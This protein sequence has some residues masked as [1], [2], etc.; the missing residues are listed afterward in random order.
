[1]RVGKID[2]VSSNTYTGWKRENLD[3]KRYFGEASVTKPAVVT[4][5]S[6]TK[7]YSV[8]G[9]IGTALSGIALFLL[10]KNKGMRLLKKQY[11]E[12]VK[13]FPMDVQY[14][15]TLAHEL[16]L[17]RKEEYKLMSVVGKQQLSSIIKNAKPEDF[18]IGGN[19]EGVK[20][21]TFRINLHNHTQA[22]DGKM[23]VEEFLDQA[24]KYADKIA[25]KYPKDSR[26]PF[27]VAITDH[28]VLSGAAEAIRIIAKN[29]LKYKNLRFVV[30]SE[31]SV[32]HINPDDVSKPLDFELMGYC[33]NPF[34]KSFSKFL[35]QVRESRNLQ[36]Q[37]FISKINEKYPDLNLNW[38]EASLYHP[39]L[40]KGT[41]NG[42]IWLTKDYATFKYYLS[43]FVKKINKNI[44]IEEQL[45]I[46]TLMKTEGNEYYKRMDNGADVHN[47]IDYF[48]KFGVA[49]HKSNEPLILDDNFEKIITNMRNSYLYPEGEFYNHKITMTA[50]D[51]FDEYRKSGDNGFFGVAHPGFISPG[52]DTYGKSLTDYCTQKGYDWRK[53]LIW[54]IFSSL[55]KQGGDLFKAAEINY[56][57]YGNRVDEG[58]KAFLKDKIADL[59]QMQLLHMGGVD[60]HKN[61]LFLKH[62]YMTKEKMQ[63]CGIEDILGDIVECE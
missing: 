49:S 43:E 42:S 6:K 16:G 50:K 44:P 18:N 22:S 14:Y 35:S 55:K 36:A 48:N 51:V 23:N 47:I 45:D 56:Q 59:P 15:K 7:K 11:N 24:A 57:S 26:P 54:T 10:P 21:L 5:K 46:S 27:V 37:E 31:I 53:H 8:F 1:M 17:R 9:A 19:L 62:E 60:C 30:G 40:A 13:S 3:N 39:N 12:M 20:N 34:N 33:L 38:E 41:S 28:D 58:Y 29:P 61:S 25:E 4:V 52:A 2:S 32:S 63:Q